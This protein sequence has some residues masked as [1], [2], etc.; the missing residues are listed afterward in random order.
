MHPSLALIQYLEIVTVVFHYL[1][2]RVHHIF[3]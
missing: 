3:H 1:A 2:L